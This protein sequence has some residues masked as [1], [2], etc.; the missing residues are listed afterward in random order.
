MLTMYSKIVTLLRE[1]VARFFNVEL[2]PC[3]VNHSP[4]RAGHWWYSIRKDYP[5][6][7]ALLT[8]FH[9]LSVESSMMGD[10]IEKKSRRIKV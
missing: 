4:T 2:T 5:V 8:I 3:L 7:L 6:S 10:I 1:N 9:G